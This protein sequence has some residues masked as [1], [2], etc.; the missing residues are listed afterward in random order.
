MSEYKNK[1]EK[2]I[3]KLLDEKREALRSFRFAI[4]GSKTRNVREG[5]NGRKEIARL[6]TELAER[7]RS[8]VA[9]KE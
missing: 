4:S 5:R 9:E 6:M 3:T 7:R 8:R 1:T 2:E